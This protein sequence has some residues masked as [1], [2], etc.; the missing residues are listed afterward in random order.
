LSIF[1][2]L[3]GFAGSA[4]DKGK[5]RRSL[6]QKGL[7]AGIYGFDHPGEFVA[8]YGGEAVGSFFKHPGNVRTADPRGLYAQQYFIFP[9]RGDGNFFVT[10]IPH[11]VEDAG[12]HGLFHP[13]S[14]ISA[15]K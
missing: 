11:S 13:Y 6:S 7:V 1:A 15:R 4:G 14:S 2:A 10:K 9:E 3:T 8:W 5:N 12:A